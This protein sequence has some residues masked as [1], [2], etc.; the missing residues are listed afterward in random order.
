MW[1]EGMHINS[2]NFLIYITTSY[3]YQNCLMICHKN[4]STKYYIG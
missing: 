2:D 3:K 4:N 1:V